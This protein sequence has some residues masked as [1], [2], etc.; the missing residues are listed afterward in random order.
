MGYYDAE[1]VTVVMSRDSPT[2]QPRARAAYTDPDDAADE[3][4]ELQED[5]AHHGVHALTVP[6][7]PDDGETDGGE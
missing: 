5:D 6:I 3:R 4:E 7:N 2:S 1:D